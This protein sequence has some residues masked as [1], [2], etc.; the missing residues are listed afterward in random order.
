MAEATQALTSAKPLNKLV[1]RMRMRQ[2]KAV[3]R[4]ETKKNFLG[5]RAVPLYLV[6][7][8]PILLLALFSIV[9]SFQHGLAENQGEL[10][11]A[12]A[13][14]YEGLILRTVVFFGCAWMFM[15]LFRG[16]IVDKSLHYYFLTPMRREVLVAAKY[17]SGLAASGILFTCTTIGS[18]IFA[19]LS[20]GYPAFARYELSAAGLSLCGN[21][22]IITLLACMGYGAFFL[23]IGLIFKNPIIPG[24]VVY[25]WEV[26]NFLLPPGLKK[27]SIIHYLHS[28]SP[29]AIPEGPFALVGEPTPRWLCVLGLLVVSAVCLLLAGWR[30]QRVEIKYGSE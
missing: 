21:Y 4:L 3:V 12:L 30:V 13:N 11:I 7:A 15:N 10:N 28:M 8:G 29:V 27:I 5:W 19:F 14:I 18:F 23:L 9:A 2:F 25:G 6:A 20:L 24:L 16:E 22:I 26:I 1:W 17:T